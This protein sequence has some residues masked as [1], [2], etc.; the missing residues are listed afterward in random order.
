VGWQCA[1]ALRARRHLNNFQ[2]RSAPDNAVVDQDDGFALNQGA[3]GIVFQLHAQMANIIG[4]LD[5]GA[6]NIMGPD[7]AEFKG[8]AGLLG[9]ANSCG[10]AAIWHG[11]DQIRSNRVF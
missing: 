3:V 11:D 8:D 4:R 10:R 9:I 1:Y 6:P 2:A 5:K 7:N